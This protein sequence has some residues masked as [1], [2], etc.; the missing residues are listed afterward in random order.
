MTTPGRSGVAKFSLATVSI[1]E[2]TPLWL[3]VLG[4]A[5][6]VHDDC[7]AR[8][9]RIKCARSGALACAMLCFTASPPLTVRSVMTYRI[10][11]SGSNRTPSKTSS[12][13]DRRPLAPV[14]TLYG[15][16]GDLLDRRISEHQLC[17]VAAQELAADR[18]VRI[19]CDSGSTTTGRVDLGGC[20]PRSPTD[21]GLHITRTRFLTYDFAAPR[22]RLW[23]TR[24]LGKP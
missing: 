22:S 12:T 10:P 21:P 11:G 19:F 17:F 15:D 4:R 24:G 9:R 18:S 14:P 6:V 20:P 1:S 5:H 7:L 13:T 2:S 8:S 16:P 3:A 23:T